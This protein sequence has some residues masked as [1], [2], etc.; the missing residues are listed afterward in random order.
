MLATAKSAGGQQDSHPIVSKE[1]I[2]TAHAVATAGLRRNFQP[3]NP[4]MGASFHAPPAAVAQP[5]AEPTVKMTS[6]AGRGRR[7]CWMAF[8][9]TRA[10]MIPIPS[11]APA[12]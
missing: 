12:V 2:G 7:P 8:S 6:S 11:T 4:S 3:L 5:P 1:K 9:S 10:P